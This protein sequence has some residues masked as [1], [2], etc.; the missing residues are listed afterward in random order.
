MPRQTDTVIMRLQLLA[1][2]LAD[3]DFKLKE[4]ERLL[5]G[6][7]MRELAAELEHAE[8]GAVAGGAR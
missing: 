1:R 5:L 3:P 6:E 8:A 4:Y 7:M 2:V